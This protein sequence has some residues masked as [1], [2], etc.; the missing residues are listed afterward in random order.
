MS[1]GKFGKYKAKAGQRIEIRERLA[2]R[3]KVESE[4]RLE[5]HGGIREGIGM[6]TYLH[7]PMDFAKTL[8]LRFRIGDLDMPERRGIPVAGR[9][10]K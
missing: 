4:K 10:R 3:K 6:K 8:K 9:R 7:S 5:I 1:A 2:L